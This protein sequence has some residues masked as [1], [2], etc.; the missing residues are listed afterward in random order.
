L[1]QNKTKQ[2]KAKQENGV[3]VSSWNI[4]VSSFGYTHRGGIARSYGVRQL[5]IQSSIEKESRI[6]AWVI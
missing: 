6:K 3:Q 4:D 1:S 5:Y 2:N